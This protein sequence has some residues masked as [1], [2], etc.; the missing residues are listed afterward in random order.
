MS[1]NIR[2]EKVSKSFSI[3]Q[4]RL[5][6]DLILG[7]A[8]HRGSSSNFIALQD[9]SFSVREG[10]SLALLG[11]NGSG[12]STCLKLLSGIIAPSSGLIRAKGRIAPLLELGSGFHPDLSGRENIYMNGAVLGIPRRETESRFDDIVEFSEIG[13]FLDVPVKFY[14]SGMIV[15]LGFS[16]AVN[17]DPEILL[18]DEV[19]AVGDTEFQKKSLERV[20]GFQQEGRTIVLV[21]HSLDAAMDFCDRAIV[22]SHGKLTFDGA[23]NDAATA[24][25]ASSRNSD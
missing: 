8:G 9:V 7:I 16:V 11:H 25:A 10:E 5:L 24:F 4:N 6:K 20:R 12:K 19:L 3:H 18:L 15:R 2:F 1:E 21:T 23:S 22:L 13:E 14:S 17:L